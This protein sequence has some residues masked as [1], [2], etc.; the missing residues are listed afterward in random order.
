MAKNATRAQS[1]GSG[2][3]LGI[4]ALI[5]MGAVVW[6]FLTTI[7]ATVSQSGGIWFGALFLFL[8]VYGIVEY[9]RK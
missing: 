4:V 6:G 8:V 1:K 2:C 7:P 9:R 3:I 5:F